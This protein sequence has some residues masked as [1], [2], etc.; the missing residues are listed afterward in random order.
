MTTPR[1]RILQAERT[2][3]TK[4]SGRRKEGMWKRGLWGWESR[5][6]FGEQGSIS[7]ALFSRMARFG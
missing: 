3:R 6:R 4:H 7:E 5:V 2:A 1:S